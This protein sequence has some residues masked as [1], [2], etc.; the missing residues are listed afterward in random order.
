MST[1]T[2]TVRTEQ[3][4][5][6]WDDPNAM[7]GLFAV[8]VWT[9]DLLIA[10]DDLAHL[11]EDIDRQLAVHR[12]ANVPGQ[13]T[14][15]ILQDRSEPWWVGYHDALL[16]ATDTVAS[17]LVPGWSDRFWRS[18]GLRFERQEDYR[19]HRW[20]IHSHQ[21]ATFSC[22]VA[23]S[24]PPHLEGT[25]AGATVLRNPQA[26]L[27]EITGSNREWHGPARSCAGLIFPGPIE[28]HPEV[29]DLI[30]HD[31]CGART[32]IVSDVCYY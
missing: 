23:L 7:V 18:W 13:Q 26:N 10:E 5:R 17:C 2:H 9:V 11:C 31:W 4:P 6:H 30:D 22:V 19:P 25:V 32:S 1:P 15:S 21:P 3:E 14:G 28:H 8:P 16:A 20:W 24:Q 27:S 12:L 29:P